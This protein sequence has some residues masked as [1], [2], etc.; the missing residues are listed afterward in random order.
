MLTMCHRPE[1]DYLIALKDL[2][3]RILSVNPEKPELYLNI[4]VK[5]YMTIAN[6]R[7]F[8]LRATAFHFD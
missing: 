4:G 6:D 2:I 8:R 7:Q 1:E 5:S 3:D